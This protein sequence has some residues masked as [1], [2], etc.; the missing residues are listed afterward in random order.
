[1]LIQI[2]ID[3]NII[4]EAI[5]N[6]DYSDSLQTLTDEQ[7]GN[8]IQAGF[9]DRYW[10][11]DLRQ[12][13]EWILRDDPT[14]RKLMALAQTHQENYDERQQEEYEQQQYYYQMVA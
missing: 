6:S 1:M 4:K 12:D 9:T 13:A 11:N 7:I 8:A 10:D 2:D 3:I 5:A 14:F